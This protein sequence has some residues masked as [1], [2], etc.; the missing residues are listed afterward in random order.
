MRWMFT[1]SPSPHQLVMQL[2]NT[3]LLWLRG[4]LWFASIHSFSVPFSSFLRIKNI[5]A[6]KSHFHR[7]LSSIHLL[8]LNIMGFTRWILRRLCLLMWVFIVLDAAPCALKSTEAEYS[9]GVLG[10]P[11]FH[12]DVFIGVSNARSFSPCAAL[13]FSLGCTSRLPVSV[14]KHCATF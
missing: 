13:L 2:I 4:Q 5:M 8:S 12:A 7:R 6:P 9:K 1:P 11:D 14:G 3:V 10:V